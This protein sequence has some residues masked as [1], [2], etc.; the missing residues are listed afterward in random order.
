ME[1]YIFEIIAE[2]DKSYIKRL[3]ASCINTETGYKGKYES[4]MPV[5]SISGR[6]NN[7]L[8]SFPANGIKA[9]FIEKGWSLVVKFNRYA[10]HKVELRYDDYIYKASLEIF[11]EDITAT[12][13]P[14]TGKFEVSGYTISNEE[15]LTFDELN[16]TILEGEDF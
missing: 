11:G 15:D 6:F 7:E 9:E 1:K 13:Y 4:E 2:R 10:F 12:Y 3:Y 8:R 14:K 5:N 16:L